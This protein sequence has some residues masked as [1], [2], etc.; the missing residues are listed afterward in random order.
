MNFIKVSLLL[1][2]ST[3]KSVSCF[4]LPNFDVNSD[5]ENS[6]DNYEKSIVNSVITTVNLSVIHV[7]S[8]VVILILLATSHRRLSNLIHKVSQALIRRSAGQSG[9]SRAVTSQSVTQV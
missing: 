3:V 9:A 4:H 2:C 8:E 6:H 7:A 1:I 5:V